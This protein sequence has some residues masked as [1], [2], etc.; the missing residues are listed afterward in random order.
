MSKTLGD[1][2]FK[3]CGTDGMDPKTLEK[4]LG[5][6]I[7][8]DVC[9]SLRDAAK[10][11]CLAYEERT[12]VSFSPRDTAAGFNLYLVS[13]TETA[14][15]IPVFVV[16][17][18]KT[19]KMLISETDSLR[20]TYEARP[21][22]TSTYVEFSVDVVEK[23]LVFSA[24]EGELDENIRCFLEEK[25][26]IPENIKVN[27]AKNASKLLA[28]ELLVPEWCSFEK[29][30][31]SELYFRHVDT[32]TYS[33]SSLLDVIKNYL[34]KLDELMQQPSDS[35]AISLPIPPWIRWA[36]ADELDSLKTERWP[37]VSVPMTREE[38]L[39]KSREYAKKLRGV[40][41]S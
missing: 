6:A 40:S 26:G 28:K 2:K 1:V 32:F 22:L 31:R 7:P 33:N 30:E 11:A 41:L 38:A 34:D 3:A 24:E 21:Y 4:A 29:P 16:T 36:I 17:D 23:G 15:N 35:E 12:I 9:I 39:E 27:L 10:K 8:P 18:E 20:L 37:A 5:T 13:K 14:K 19:G 25:L